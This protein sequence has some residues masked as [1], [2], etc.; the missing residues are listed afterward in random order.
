[1][2]KIFY[3]FAAV[4][5]ACFLG[6]GVSAVLIDH[7]LAPRLAWDLFSM[8]GI[9]FGLPAVIFGLEARS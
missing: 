5:F 4:A 7:G 9:L 6:M 8:V 3:F 2:S 1:M